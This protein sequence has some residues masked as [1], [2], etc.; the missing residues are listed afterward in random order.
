MVYVYGN[1]DVSVDGILEKI[2]LAAAEENVK[3]IA[4]GEGGN[5]VSLRLGEG[6]T[7]TDNLFPFDPGEAAIDIIGETVLC[8]DAVVTDLSGDVET[9]KFVVSA[10]KK[11]HAKVVLAFFGFAVPEAVACHADAAVVT[12]AAAEKITGFS[13][14]SEVGVA[15][16]VGGMYSVGLKNVVIVSPDDIIVAVGDEITYFDKKESFDGAKFVAQITKDIADGRSAKEAIG[17]A[18]GQTHIYIG[19]RIK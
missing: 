13:L 6:G 1:F 11:K 9:T 12:A 14:G 8:S 10:V 19:D 5:A 18:I 17:L 2:A 7:D 15:L 16:V 4:C 3:T